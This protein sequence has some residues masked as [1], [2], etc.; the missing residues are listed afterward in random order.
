[1]DEQRRKFDEK[2]GAAN[3]TEQITPTQANNGINSDIPP[4]YANDPD[5][6]Q[7]IQAS[8]GTEVE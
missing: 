4:E 7:A 1:M 6:W 2:S 5:L 3:Q 8:L